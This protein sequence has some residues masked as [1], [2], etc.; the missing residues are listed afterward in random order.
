MDDK[1]W[2]EL[3][4][5]DWEYITAGLLRYAQKKVQRLSWSRSSKELPGGKEVQDLVYEAIARVLR[6]ERCWDPEKHPNL[7]G[8]LC[9]VIDSLVS[10][11]VESWENRNVGPLPKLWDREEEPPRDGGAS[12][13]RA[14]LFFDELVDEVGND[15]E[16][17]QL[18][19]QVLDGRTKASDIAETTGF[20][21][22]RVYRLKE[23]LKR[24]AENVLAR[25]QGKKLV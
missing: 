15:E 11:L 2:K 21:V 17:V 10:H 9:N 1:T 8:Y 22:Q 4:S 23:K 12:Q 5:A 14:Q 18:I 24:R 13:E 3:Q 6:G 20:D 16:L 19:E 25:L 7:F